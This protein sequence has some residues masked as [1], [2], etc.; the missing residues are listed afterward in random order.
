MR[1]ELLL[2]ETI[3]RFLL[4][5]GDADR[6]QIVCRQFLGEVSVTLTMK[7]EEFDIYSSAD[8]GRDGEDD[9]STDAIRAVLLKSY[10]ENFRYGHK[11]GVNRIRISADRSGGFLYAT[12]LAM[13]LGIMVGLA[14]QFLLP[15]EGC[16]V[17]KSCLLSPVRSMFMNALKSII[18]PVVFLSIVTCFSQYD[19][20]SQFGKL[21]AKVLGMYI[22][23]TIIAVLLALG[24]SSVFQPGKPGF[25]LTGDVSVQSV[26]IDTAVDTSLLSTII[27]IVPSNFTAPFVE[28]NTLQ[29][30]F[31]AVLCGISLGIM[32]D[33]AAG[34]KEFF[35]NLNSLFLTIT[36]L[37]ARL[38][39]VAVFCSL[40]L[41]VMELDFSA[42]LSL[43]GAAV[44]HV[45]AILCMMAIY[46]VLILLLARLNPLKFY[47][48]IREG[49]MT[50][51]S[52]ASSSAAMPTNLKICTDKLGISPKVC[53]FSVPLGATIN[54]DGTCILLTIM[55]LFLARA[56]GVTITSSEIMSIAVTII[57]LSLGTPG[58]PGAGIVCI[59][60]VL[61][62]LHVPVEAVGLIL[63]IYP[64]FDM[65][66]TM[67]NTTGDMAT[68]LIV[69]KSEKLLD[70][71]KYNE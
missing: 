22:L 14:A 43:V 32:G 25:A 45:S 21:G 67:S 37:I 59:G 63:P 1:G 12:L 60:I 24:L 9:Y 41:M 23:T 26:Q 17:L 2:E 71:K 65:F 52:L 15:E 7:G 48:K 42:F 13:L 57:L 18:A 20:I 66:D 4:H 27:D 35:D 28:S 36:C 49:M 8:E 68:S 56:Y 44:L 55:G 51:F 11:N 31:L 40:S 34:L 3:A 29:L 19:D 16:F 38:I 6:F 33:T 58:V 64:I 39:P 53:N 50:S 5:S 69:A 30:I 46:G 61:Q 54:M 62:A 70:Q 47:S 10:G